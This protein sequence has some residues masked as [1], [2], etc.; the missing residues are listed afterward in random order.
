MST[1]RDIWRE[2]VRANRIMALDE[3]AGQEEFDR[4]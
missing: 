2:S 3:V 4:F 1:W